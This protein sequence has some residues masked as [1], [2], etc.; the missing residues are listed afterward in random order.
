VLGA[1]AICYLTK[2]FDVDGLI[3]GLHAALK[4]HDGRSGK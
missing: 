3:Q 1:G 2:P 4:K